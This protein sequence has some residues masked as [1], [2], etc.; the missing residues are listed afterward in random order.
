MVSPSTDAFTTG[1]ARSALTTAFKM[2]DRYVSFAP[3]RSYSAFFA[4]RTCATRPKF[5]SKTECTCAEVRR[6][7]IMCSAIRFRITDIGTT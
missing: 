7:A 5:T 6:L 3:A 2:N 4:S 1:T